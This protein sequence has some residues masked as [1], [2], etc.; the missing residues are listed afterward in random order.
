LN[1][2]HD[3][4]LELESLHQTLTLTKFTIQK[5]DKTPLGQ[6][7]ANTVAPEVKLCF[8]ALQELLGSINGTRLCLGW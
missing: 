3:L 8:A 4:V 1:D 6:S 2:H 7:M 5:Y